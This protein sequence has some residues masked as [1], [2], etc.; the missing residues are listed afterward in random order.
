L[1]ALLDL[2]REISFE[3]AKNYDGLMCDVLVEAKTD[4]EGQLQGR[5]TQNKLVFF[6]PGADI[7]GK[8]GGPAEEWI[9]KIAP[10]KVLRAFP[11]VLYGETVSQ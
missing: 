11:S 4:T 7:M 6:S 1:Q 8:T 10:V 2:Q 9:G 5:T 3:L